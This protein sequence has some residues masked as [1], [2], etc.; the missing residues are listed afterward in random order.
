MYSNGTVLYHYRTVIENFCLGPPLL[1]ANL[2]GQREGESEGMYYDSP[3]GGTQ[4]YN[5][6]SPLLTQLPQ[7]APPAAEG[8][9][10]LPGPSGAVAAGVQLLA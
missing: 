4:T 2:D 5:N 9:A 7:H 10:T 1:Q 8:D 6:V 3:M